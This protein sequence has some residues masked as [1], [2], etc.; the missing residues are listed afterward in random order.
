MV[1]QMSILRYIPEW[2]SGP[3]FQKQARLW[4]PLYP[5]MIDLPFNVVKSQMAAGTAEPSFTSRWLEQGLG[6]E[7]EDV[8]KH[9][10]RSMFGVHATRSILS[11]AR[12]LIVHIHSLTMVR[13]PE[14]QEK[15]E[16]EMDP[17]VG[18]NFE[19]RAHTE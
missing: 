11:N 2:F 3:G 14:I 8:L 13:Y 10:S 19:D 12:I 17:V 18:R 15:V 6:A 1:N 5:A 16:A 9:A 7:D 4:R